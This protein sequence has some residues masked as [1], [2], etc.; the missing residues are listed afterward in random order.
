MDE[1]RLYKIGTG[2]PL[3]SG[4]ALT[5]A[6]G[7]G[8][9]EA[10]VVIRG[11][12]PLALIRNEASPRTAATEY[13]HRLLGEVGVDLMEPVAC[14]PA[15]IEAARPLLQESPIRRAFRELRE[16]THARTLL[17]LEREQMGPEWLH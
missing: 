13:L 6:Y 3:R 12:E 16:Q 17:R 7:D 2:E 9:V 4:V 8:L 14:E 15:A 5:G 1:I 10:F 11:F